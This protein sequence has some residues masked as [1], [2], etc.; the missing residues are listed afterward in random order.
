MLK[1]GWKV[2]GLIFWPVLAPL[3]WVKRSLSDFDEDAW[4]YKYAKWLWSGDVASKK[5]CTYWWGR[6]IGT[7]LLLVVFGT[8]IFGFLYLIFYPLA[9][10]FGF[11][12]G[13][14]LKGEL[15]PSLIYKSNQKRDYRFAPWEIVFVLGLVTTFVGSLVYFGFFN[16][17][18]G[19]EVGKIVGIVAG[20]V[21]GAFVILAL[22]VFSLVKTWRTGVSGLLKSGW[23]TL[24]EKAC[25]DL[26]VH[27]KET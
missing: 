15:V 27:K 5:A 13:R 3:G 17:S 24:W 25:P 7:T 18:L 1:D 4:H 6:I 10:F 14:R 2:F 21:I 16:P 8:L 22:V 11:H 19:V 12:H 26:V 9:W 23:K 20:S